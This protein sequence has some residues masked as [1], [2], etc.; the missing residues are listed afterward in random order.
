MVHFSCCNAREFQMYAEAFKGSY[1]SSSI[2]SQRRFS[3]A[4]TQKYDLFDLWDWKHWL[5]SLLL[6]VEDTTVYNALSVQAA[7]S[8]ISDSSTAQ[9]SSFR[10]LILQIVAMIIERMHDAAPKS[11]KKTHGSHYTASRHNGSECWQ[12]M[13]HKVAV[14]ASKQTL[15]PSSWML[16][17]NMHSNHLATITYGLIVAALL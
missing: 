17:S 6:R 11:I 16:S 4:W 5:A 13:W 14:E 3:A 1:P 10:I 9:F 15:Q 2:I 7:S 8:I 12:M